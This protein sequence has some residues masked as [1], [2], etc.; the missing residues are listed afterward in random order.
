MLSADSACWLAL[1]GRRHGRLQEGATGFTWPLDFDIKFSHI[2]TVAPRVEI[3]M[4]L[5]FSESVPAPLNIQWPKCFQLQGGGALP[6]WPL[7]RGSAPGPRWGLCPQ[8]PV[9]GSCSALAMV[10]PTT[11]RP[12][13]PPLEKILWA[14]LDA[15]T[16]LARVC[17]HSDCIADRDQ[18]CLC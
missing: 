4:H 9:I 17:W 13:G 6:P 15:G 3:Q 11:D 5:L 7:S 12:Y 18:A 8:T 16:P 2:I 10:P 1:L 14:P